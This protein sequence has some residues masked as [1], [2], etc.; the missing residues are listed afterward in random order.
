MNASRQFPTSFRPS[1]PRDHADA[2]A[3]VT[4]DEASRMFAAHHALLLRYLARLTGDPDRAADAAQ[5]VFVR[6]TDRPPTFAP[7][8]AAAAGDPTRAWLFTVATN[9]VREGGRPH[10]RRAR[11]LAAGARRPAVTAALADLPEQERVAL[12]MR[13]EG[14]PHREIAAAVGTT[15]DSVGAL[16]ARAL[17]TLARALPLDAEA[18]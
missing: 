13:E 2:P 5:E 12:L 10:A 11:L 8:A 1:S 4:S 3:P 14:A 16:L 18:S 7:D 17:D 6:L 15:T 9:V